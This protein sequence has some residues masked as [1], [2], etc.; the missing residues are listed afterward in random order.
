[1]RHQVGNPQLQFA[2]GVASLHRCHAKVKE[3]RGQAG[4]TQP[5]F[6]QILQAKPVDNPRD[7]N[8]ELFLQQLLD[9]LGAAGSIASI[10]ANLTAVGIQ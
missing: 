1:M 5:G 3:Q 8:C 4:H 7:A 10:G 9:Q 6:D 2:L